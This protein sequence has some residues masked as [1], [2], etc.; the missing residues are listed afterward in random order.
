MAAERRENWRDVIDKIVLWLQANSEH[1]AA[2]ESYGKQ[3]VEVVWQA[4]V[5]VLTTITESTQIKSP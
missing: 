2:V 5:P 4:G 3:H 1:R